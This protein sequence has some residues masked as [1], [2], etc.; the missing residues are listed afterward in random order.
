M[1]RNILRNIFRLLILGVL[2]SSPALANWTGKDAASATITFANPNTCSS[3]VCTPIA[4][5]ADSNGANLASVPTAG[6][7]AVSNT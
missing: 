6:A 1:V 3:V 4:A 7:D 2:I 5:I